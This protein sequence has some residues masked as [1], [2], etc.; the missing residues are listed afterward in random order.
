LR[1]SRPP[2]LLQIEALVR[3]GWWSPS[4]AKACPVT[5]TRTKASINVPGIGPVNYSVS[6]Y[7]GVPYALV[8]AAELGFPD[9][10]RK[11]VAA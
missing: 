7:S 9:P 2:G 1:W 6:A 8:D 5:F 11:S 4:P 3:D 10:L